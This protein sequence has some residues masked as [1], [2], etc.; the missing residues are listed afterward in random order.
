MLMDT[1]NSKFAKVR[2]LPQGSFTWSEGFWLDRFNTC[3]NVTIPHVLSIFDD[4]ESFFHQVENFRIAAG[5]SE[6]EFRGNPYGD[7]DFYKLMEG[8]AYTFS[9]SK[10]PALSAQMDAYIALI[11]AAQ[12]PDGYLSTKQIIGERLSN[13]TVRHG[14][15]DDFEEYNFGHLFTAACVHRR[16]T[17][18]NNFMDIA[19]KCAEYLQ[20]LYA[21]VM[22]TQKARTAV[23][24]SHYMGLFEMYRTTGDEKYLR[25]G[26]TAIQV[27][28]LVNDGTDDNQDRIPLIEH[29][30]IVGHAVRS[31]YLYAGVADM[32]LETG[33]E[34]LLPVL[35]SCW[36][37]LMD[38]KIY[39]TGGCG[40]LYTGTSPFGH[41]LDA[42]RVH[43]AFGYEY[44]LPNV[45]AYNETCGTLG[46]IFWAH[47]MFAI[48]PKAEYMD[49]IERSYYNLV[50][51][52]VSLDG[53]KYFY[54]NML[55]RT[56]TLDYPVMWPVERS[57]TFECFCCPT[58]LSRCIPQ[59]MEYTYKLSHDAVWCGMYGASRAAISLDNGAAFTLAQ[60]TGYPWDGAIRFEVTEVQNPAPF[61]LKV[62]IPGWAESGSL[63]FGDTVR[64][65]TAA[66]ADSFIDV[67]IDTPRGAVVNLQLDMPVR[68]VEANAMVEENTNQVCVLRGP[69]VYCIESPDADTSTLDD[70]MLLSNAAFTEEW[71]DIKGVRVLSLA[72]QAALVVR[73]AAAGSTQPGALYR[74]MRVQA[75]RKTTIRMIPYFAWD[76]R[77]F[78]EM[79]IWTPVHYQLEV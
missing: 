3:A 47:R 39:I 2:S 60:T 36:D 37:N 26:K 42:Q 25:L 4:S 70:V 5:L 27:R 40:A 56:K 54:E 50:S 44:Q 76:N 35:N 30:A 51:A 75:L 41:L 69:L 79:R 57:D 8:M 68:Y 62:R 33:D 31:T 77:G 23:C 49:L 73:G 22:R 48:C 12:Q 24:P 66:D 34:T 21:A 65:L 13:G 15:I 52:A 46:H 20:G 10:D 9:V 53:N 63:C 16:I 6:G 14:D 18:K 1:S 7:G 67:R 32:Y 78:G 17:G 72:T 64:A 71:M 43:Q 19:V 11:A 58:N 55:R 45:T 74:P 38:K 61:T 29:R 59:T 28:D